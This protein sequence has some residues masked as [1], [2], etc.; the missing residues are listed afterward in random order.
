MEPLTLDQLDRQLVHALQVDGR[1]SFSRIAAALGT[2]DRTV[3][4]RYRRLRS[5]GALR[6][7]ALPDSRR[8]G[9]VD[10]LARIRCAPDTV[11]PVAALLAR[12]EDISWVGL[13]SGGS[14]VTCVT[15]TRGKPDG[16]G[17]LLQRLPRSPRITSITAYC[18]LRPVAGTAG[19]PGR[20]RALSERQIRHLAPPPSPEPGRRAVRLTEPEE[21][22]FSVLA[23]DGRADY[24]V[25][26]E[27]AGWSE[28][29]TRRRLED[30]R[31][32]G[33]LYFDVDIDPLL[34]GYTVEAV[35]WLTVAPAQLA[36]VAR[37]LSTHEEVAFAAA[38]TGS[39]NLVAFVVCP[40]SDALYDYLATR[41]GKLRGVLQVE[42]AL[43][44]RH[45]KRAGALLDTFARDR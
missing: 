9:E 24:R 23:K 37:A 8:I 5:V 4:R 28:T 43:V 32:T 27:A 22:L 1:A 14:E 6:V 2:S 21:R 12:R 3:A 41:I 33:I 25:L 13:T 11:I 31:R 29:T 18:L 39:V 34:L 40:D 16:D 17:L 45:A 20:T 19:W 10:W 44:T 42:T 38:T 36:V 15:R 7:V 35:L 30:L 26:A